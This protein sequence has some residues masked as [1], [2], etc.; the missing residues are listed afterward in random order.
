MT[1]PKDVL[2]NA[3]KRRISRRTVLTSAAAAGVTAGVGPHI[4]KALGETPVKIGEIDPFTGT[5]AA[6]GAS[7]NDG[8]KL[9]LSQINKAGGIL[10]RR[11][12]IIA[13]DDAADVGKATVKFHKLTDKDKVDFVM[14]S[15]SSAVALALEHAATIKKSFYVATGG[16]VDSVTGTHCSWTTFKTCSDTWMLAAALSKTLMSKFGKRWYFS[17]P[18]YAWGHFLYA[19]FSKILAQSGGTNLGNAV[20]PLGASGTLEMASRK[21]MQHRRVCFEDVVHCVASS[22]DWSFEIVR[23]RG[24]STEAPLSS[25]IFGECGTQIVGVEVGPHAIDEH[26]LSIRGRELT[27]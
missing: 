4:I 16:H 6:L 22:Q 3:S 11:V 19:G 7:Q 24:Q 5:Y 12:D 10:G 23:L 18:D 25:P 1:T 8:S 21:R 27:L 15:V 20:M 13:E 17:T 2:T 9:A 26:Q 14:G